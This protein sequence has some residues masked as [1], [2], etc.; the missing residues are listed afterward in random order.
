[1]VWVPFS[2]NYRQVEEIYGFTDAYT[3]CK[4][5]VVNWTSRGRIQNSF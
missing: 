1:M 3:V 5:V 2:G 4:V